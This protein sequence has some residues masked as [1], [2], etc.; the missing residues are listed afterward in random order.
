[1]K[2]MLPTLLGLNLIPHEITKVVI[3]LTVKS[4]NILFPVEVI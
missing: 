2:K 1:M 4:K 3:L